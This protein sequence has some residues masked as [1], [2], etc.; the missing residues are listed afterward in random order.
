MFGR[1]FA[2]SDPDQALQNVVPDLGQ[3]CLT[4]DGISEIFFE[5]C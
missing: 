1:L 2:D 3:N 4:T 5:K